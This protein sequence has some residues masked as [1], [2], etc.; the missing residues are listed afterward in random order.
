MNLNNRVHLEKILSY[1]KKFG[2]DQSDAI[3]NTGTSFNL[4]SQNA[5]IDKYKL[6]GS[7]VVGI[8]VIKDQKIGLSYSESLDD[9]ALELAAKNAVENARYADINEH[10]HIVVKSESDLIAKNI[11]DPDK[12]S[13][14]E[15]IDFTLKLESEVRRRDNK[16]QA[17][18]YNGLSESLAE[19]YYLNS[20]GTFAFDD[21]YY[22]SCYTSALLKE[23]N[24]NSMHFHGVISRTLK[25]LDLEACVSESLE[26][27]AN[28]LKAKPVKTG[29][30]DI[31]FTHDQFV[32]VFQCFQ[33]I[34]SAKAAWDKVN[35][36]SEKLGQKIANSE[37][38]FVDMPQYQD[39]FFK[40]DF[41]SEGVKRSDLVLIENGVL[42][43]FYHNSSTAHY[44]NTK[45]TG[46]A[47]RGPRSPLSVAGTNCFIAAGKTSEQSIRN[48]EYLEIH[49]L[50]GLHSG[51]NAISG[52]F[53]F[54]A[55]GYLCKDGQR[56]Q[57]VKGIT[58]AGNYHKM[59]MQIKAI[60]DMIT[61]NTDNSFFLP[62]I[63]F[64]SVAVAGN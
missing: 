19:T 64:D 22:L 24:D 14:Q 53:S 49:A 11:Y 31:I 10:E 35:P 62:T 43:S 23:G 4:S 12:A 17:V 39:A 55:S 16:V 13:T 1:A 26:H 60:G 50:Q 37:L 52:E 45:T 48:G 3:L 32:A 7:S 58:V 63:R 47:S 40:Y 25:D 9:D 59:L 34:F 51:A 15:K 8:R 30:Y 44:F 42:Q 20:L 6:S 28:W 29:K 27:A 21:E 33:N 5:E 2:A 18:P 61:P 36:F 46:H 41:D 54:G 57:P 38:T 56:I